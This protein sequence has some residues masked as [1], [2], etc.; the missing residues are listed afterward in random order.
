MSQVLFFFLLPH[1]FRY[2]TVLH[3][4]RCQLTGQEQGST[5]FCT[6]N[7]NLI[8][9][10]LIMSQM[11]FIQ[12]VLNVTV[13]DFLN[14]RCAGLETSIFMLI[15]KIRFLSL[16]LLE[17]WQVSPEHFKGS[18]TARAIQKAYFYRCHLICKPINNAVWTLAIDL[19]SVGQRL[20]GWLT[21]PHKKMYLSD[22]FYKEDNLKHYGFVQTRNFISN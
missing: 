20:L 10:V 2:V 5:E 8:G 16:P 18:R 21:E 1:H 6:A 4:K 17:A 22:Y 19:A 7:L 3:I 15:M 11:L 12:I 14:Y 13:N 9:R